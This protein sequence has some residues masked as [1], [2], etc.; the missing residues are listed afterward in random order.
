MSPLQAIRRHCLECCGGSHYELAKC[1]CPDCILW[2]FR[3]GMR[4]ETAAEHGRPVDRD[5]FVTES[6]RLA[7]ELG[8]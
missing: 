8:L 1:C 7:Q 2:P 6:E 4:P 3:F 5:T